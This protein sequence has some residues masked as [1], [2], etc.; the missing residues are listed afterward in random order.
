M[1]NTLKNVDGILFY[2]IANDCYGNMNTKEMWLKFSGHLKEEEKKL[3]KE[4]QNS[5]ITSISE[6]KLEKYIKIK[7]Q[8]DVHKLLPKYYAQECNEKEHSLVYDFVTNSLKDFIDDRMTQEEKD[9]ADN[10][11]YSMSKDDLKNFINDLDGKYM[12]LS[13]YIAYMLFLAK[14]R[15]Y[16]IDDIEK[17]EIR[18]IKDAQRNRNLIKHLVNDYII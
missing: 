5:D 18:R 15:Y 17:M 4:I 6:D 10:L 8:I 12:E 14:E 9:G 2:A 1:S 11:V 16:Y 7:N 3:L 13:T